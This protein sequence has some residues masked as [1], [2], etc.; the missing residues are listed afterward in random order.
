MKCEL[1]GILWSGQTVVINQKPFYFGNVQ[2]ENGNIF[3]L[4]VSPEIF[5]KNKGDG[6]PNK[7]KITIETIE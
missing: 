6:K 7:I 3:N 1:V 4:P 5:N 2:T